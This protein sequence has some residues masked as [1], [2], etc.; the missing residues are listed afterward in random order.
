[1]WIDAIGSTTKVSLSKRRIYMYIIVAK[2]N[3]ISIIDMLANQALF[4]CLKLFLF[5]NSS[6]RSVCINQNTNW[7]IL[8]DN[9]TLSGLMQ[10]AELSSH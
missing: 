3:I 8:S 9:K 1:M 6:M 7:I 10:A 5:F 4:W 2:Y